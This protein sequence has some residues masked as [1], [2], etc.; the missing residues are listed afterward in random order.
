[1]SWKKI[2]KAKGRS[3]ASSRYSD[4][5]LE[6]EI[7]EKIAEELG[8]EEEVS[9]DFDYF[10]IDIEVS[11]VQESGFYG[12]RA[13]EEF[14]IRVQP[15]GRIRVYDEADNIVKEI[16]STDVDIELY[17]DSSSPNIKVDRENGAFIFATEYY[18]LGYENGKIAV[19]VVL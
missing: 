18:I 14:A 13:T 15:S 11:N 3:S 9:L 1:M 16:K 19:E 7:A 8:F 4:D 12:A 10:D 2:V 6:Q 5:D 17:V